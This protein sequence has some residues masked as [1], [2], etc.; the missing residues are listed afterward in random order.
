MTKG[1]RAAV[2]IAAVVVALAAV[3]AVY[4]LLP[5][6]PRTIEGTWVSED[7][8][9]VRTYEGGTARQFMEATYGKSN[10]PDQTYTYAMPGNTIRISDGRGTSEEADSLPPMTFAVRFSFGNRVVTLYDGD[11]RVSSGYRAGSPEARLS[12]LSNN[13]YR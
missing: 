9:V 12:H 13:W 3:A 4:F 1:R 7:G 6:A 11:Q 5:T 8:L 2:T 10:T